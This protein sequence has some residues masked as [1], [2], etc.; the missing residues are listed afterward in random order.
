M[1]IHQPTSAH[2]RL[3]SL[4]HTPQRV[5]LLSLTSSPLTR[6]CRSGVSIVTTSWD[7]P[8]RLPIA[9]SP[10]V[11]CATGGVN[12]PSYRHCCATGGVT[13][14]SIP[15]LK[16][17]YISTIS[18]SAQGTSRQRPTR[19]DQMPKPFCGINTKQGC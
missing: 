6:T 4:S 18:F 8:E 19:N 14:L 12:F 17:P 13:S 15:N 16:L 5:I 2:F 7:L 10:K 9:L 1:P 11:C 3:F